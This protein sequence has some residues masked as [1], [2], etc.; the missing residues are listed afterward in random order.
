MKKL[1]YKGKV[2]ILVNSKAISASEFNIMGMQIMNNVITIVSKTA[3]ADGNISL[4]LVLSGNYLTRFSSISIS[5][6]NGK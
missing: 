3:G 5:Y 2:I 1:N 4:N 6:P